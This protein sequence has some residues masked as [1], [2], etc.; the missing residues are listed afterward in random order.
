MRPSVFERDALHRLVFDP[1]AEPFRL[2]LEF[3]HQFISVDRFRESRKVFDI[4]GLGQQSARKRS[5][6]NQRI[7][8]GSCRINGGGQSRRSASDDD[9]LFHDEIFSRLMFAVGCRKEPD[10]GCSSSS[11]EGNMA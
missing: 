5:G 10:P 9:Q 3:V 6:Q 2:L 1:C 8:V 4:A 11:F 7:E